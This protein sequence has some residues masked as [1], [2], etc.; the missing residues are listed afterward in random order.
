MKTTKKLLAL[1][2]STL[3]CAATYAAPLTVCDFEDYPIG[4]EW[5]MWNTQSSTAKV[6]ADPL[7]ANNK[8]LH[9]V[10]KDWVC[11]PEFTLST[12]LTGKALTDRYPTLRYQLYRSPS[13]TDDHKQFAVF[14]GSEE[15]YRDEG[16]PYQGDKGVWQT[17]A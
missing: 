17:K 11:H 12:E 3:M 2:L 6:E 14:L 9:V 5:T 13:E 1:G 7:N 4:T 8:V 10:L 15:L 16:Y